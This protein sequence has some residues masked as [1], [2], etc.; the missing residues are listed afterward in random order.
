MFSSVVRL[1]SG[2]MAFFSWLFCI[3]FCFAHICS[4]GFLSSAP[5][6]TPPLSQHRIFLLLLPLLSFSLH[7]LFDPVYLV[8]FCY[9]LD[10]WSEGGS[11][12]AFGPSVWPNGKGDVGTPHGMDR[13]KRSLKEP[14][15]RIRIPLIN[16]FSFSLSLHWN[17]HAT[18]FRKCP[19]NSIENAI[20][21]H[22]SI[23]W[24]VAFRTNWER[25][26]EPI[27][28]WIYLMLLLE[29]PS[30]HPIIIFCHLGHDHPNVP[31]LP[32]VSS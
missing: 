30:K 15:G 3:V 20:E 4:N 7:L 22:E 13:P 28:T 10:Q 27:K 9:F 31:G 6:P 1:F 23:P 16:E 8:L 14:E 19:K 25:K 2:Y 18:G 32:A 21:S 26:H 12:W 5:T 17:I 24:N 11:M 29:P